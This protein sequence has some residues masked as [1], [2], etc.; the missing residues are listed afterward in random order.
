MLVFEVGSDRRGGFRSRLPKS[1]EDSGCESV[2]K[3]WRFT[4]LRH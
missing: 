1:L 2:R 3:D 4:V